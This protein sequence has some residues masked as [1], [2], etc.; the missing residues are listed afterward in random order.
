[1]RS[2]PFVPFLVAAAALSGTAGAETP[3]LQGV[4]S[5]SSSASVE[6]TKDLLNVVMTTT[7]ARADAAAVQSQLKQA[8]DAA[9]AE[10]RKVAK[11][12]Q[13]EVQTGNFSLYPR[14]AAKGGINGWQG[15][16]ELVIEG[17][18]MPA[19]G[20]LTGRIGTMTIGRV[21][22][23]VSR[24]LREKVEGEVTAQAIARY[25]AKAAD[26]AK[27][28]GYAGYAIRE[29]SVGGSEPQMYSPAPML[30]AKTMS[31]SADEALPVEA[32]KATI[33]VNV[34][35]SVQLTR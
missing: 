2:R 26:Y 10:A 8:L 4:V 1:M 13:L 35:G 7:R 16:A 3:A 20:Q 15:S 11:P 23:G 21:G 33:V 28:F 32:G 24:E 34:N 12:G 19:I 25:R 29:V 22:Y 17:K 14:Y 27:Q 31:A 5:L 18:D 6:V 9:L 30:R